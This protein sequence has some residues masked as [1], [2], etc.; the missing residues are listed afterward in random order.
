MINEI[1][2]GKLFYDRQVAFLEANDVEGLVSTQ[3]AADAE[4]VGFDF[5]VKGQEALRAH[6][7]NYLLGLGSI[8]LASTDKF[9]ETD[10]TIFFEATIDVSAGQARVYDAFVLKGGKA[11]YHFTGLLGFS[12]QE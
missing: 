11:V 8:K 1:T 9:T 5:K 10:D 3:Y 12:P 6:F 2:P 4:L 7:T